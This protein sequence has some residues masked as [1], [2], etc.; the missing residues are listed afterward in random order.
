[1]P[2]VTIRVQFQREQQYLIINGIFKLIIFFLFISTYNDFG[3]R[4]VESIP[5]G[6][7]FLL[8]KQQEIRTLFKIN[9]FISQ[10]T[11]VPFT[12][13]TRMD[14][15]SVAAAIPGRTEV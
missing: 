11:F 10:F 14:E 6:E 2:L 7:I 1:L 15:A 3:G 5:V 8:S 13:N 12:K 9:N 4:K